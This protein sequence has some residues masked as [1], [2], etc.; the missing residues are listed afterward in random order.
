MAN[1][2]VFALAMANEPRNAADTQ[3]KR[4]A[5]HSRAELLLEMIQAESS[6]FPATLDS[7]RDSDK[8][9]DERSRGSIEDLAAE[10]ESVTQD[11]LGQLQAA[12]AFSAPRVFRRMHE[13][14][15]LD[16]LPALGDRVQWWSLKRIANWLPPTNWSAA[17]D[18]VPFAQTA[19]GE[20]WCWYP[21]WAT[22]NTP[23]VVLVAPNEETRL[24][25]PNFEGFLFRQLLE[26]LSGV[27]SSEADAAK[28]AAHARK[29]VDAVRPFLRSNWL[30]LLAA[31][32]ERPPHLNE[33]TGHL[34]FLEPE[35]AREI[36]QRELPFEDLSPSLLHVS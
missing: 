7:P 13:E 25:A 16:G 11:F 23:P 1:R 22:G 30:A 35:E 28:F 6:H 26:Q 4:L 32:Q 36:V 3:R 24:Y 21:S 19:S 33:R 34:Q 8:L 29:G 5:Y 10:G 17:S 20:L 31:V 2:G 15:A 27:T 18:A 12:R 9:P 14:S